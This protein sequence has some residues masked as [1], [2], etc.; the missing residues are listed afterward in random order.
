MQ[1]CSE[2]AEQGME[3]SKSRAG[4]EDWGQQQ[5]RGHRYLPPVAPPEMHPL[6]YP[7]SK[8]TVPNLQTISAQPPNH[9]Y[10]T[11]NSKVPNLQTHITILQSPIRILQIHTANQKAQSQSELDFPYPQMLI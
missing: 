6:S 2:L 9:Q 4:V 3:Q 11:S 8:T 5:G 7:K 10:P 1:L